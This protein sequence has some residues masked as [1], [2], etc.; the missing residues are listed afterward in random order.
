MDFRRRLTAPRGRYRGD[1]PAPWRH[2][3]GFLLSAPIL[4]EAFI[5]LVVNVNPAAAETS[6]AF[7]FF[8]MLT[9]SLLRIFVKFPAAA[10]E[11]VERRQI[12]AGLW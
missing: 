10:Q 12:A 7:C 2:G 8:A 4:P 11:T 3:A 9:G 6:A 1:W 5:L